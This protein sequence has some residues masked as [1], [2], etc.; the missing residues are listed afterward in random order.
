MRA[1]RHLGGE[2]TSRVR[3][4]LRTVG[5]DGIDDRILD[6]AGVLDPAIV[7]TLDAIHL[8]RSGV[9]GGAE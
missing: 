8:G 2:A 4:A 7:R 3:A 6:A 9:G 5:L 1:V